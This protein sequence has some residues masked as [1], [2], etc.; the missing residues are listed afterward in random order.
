MMR[1]I[2]DW[3]VMGSSSN[4]DAMGNNLTLVLI[5]LLVAFVFGQM[6]A[7]LYIYTHQGVSYSRSFTQS[8]VLLTIIVTL[9]MLV[10]GN[11]IVIAFGLIGALSVI[12]F[13][14]ILKD[15]RDTAF[16]FYAL[17]IGMAAGTRNFHLALIGAIVFSATLLYFHWTGFG[18]RN[19]G[20]G[21]LRFR[22]QT[23]EAGLQD[24]QQ[25][26]SRHCHSI[27]LTSQRFHEAGDGEI[28][29]RLTMR[30]PGRSEEMVRDLH[31][32]SGVSKV[33]FVLHEEQAEI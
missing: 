32:I 17:I 10:I 8:I 13:R 4:T 3:V 26:L 33:N 21:F 1:E 22:I 11:N 12:R 16:V 15:T 14:N 20:D 25:L 31:T 5:A 7:W 30:D 27:S 18:G 2:V 24:V 6:A 28:A 23:G 29:Y 19:T 9:A